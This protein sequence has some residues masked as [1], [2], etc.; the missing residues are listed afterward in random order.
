MQP[1]RFGLLDLDFLLNIRQMALLTDARD[2]ASD[3]FAVLLLLH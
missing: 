1:V 3:G 2:F